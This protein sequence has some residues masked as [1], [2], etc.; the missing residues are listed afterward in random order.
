[1]RLDDPHRGLEH[2]APFAEL[3]TGEVTVDG[4]KWGDPFL[5]FGA[6]RA[7]GSEPVVRFIDGVELRAG[8]REWSR[9]SYR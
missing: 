5:T 7:I 9:F 1:M 3:L 2:H 4:T 6:F 8:R